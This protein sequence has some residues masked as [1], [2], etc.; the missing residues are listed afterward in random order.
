MALFDARATGWRRWIGGRSLVIGIPYGWL[1]V[2]FLAPFLIVLNYSA[3]DMGAVRPE[4]I[5]QWGEGVVKLALKYSNY[6]T[7]FGDDLYLKAYL[8]SLKFAG[9]TT[10]LC[11]V[12]GV[13]V[14]LWMAGLTPASRA[15]MLFLVTI[16]FWTNL[17]VRNYAWLIILRQDGWATAIARRAIFSASCS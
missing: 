8:S 10:L 4:N 6:Q 3:S 7:I 12:L 5:V 13:P 9:V 15:M 1:L 17:L 2:F 14:A 16:P 11:L